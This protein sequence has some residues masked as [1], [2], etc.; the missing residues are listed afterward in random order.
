[1][2]FTPHSNFWISLFGGFL[3]AFA[4]CARVSAAQLMAPSADRAVEI[5]QLQEVKQ[6]ENAWFEV[7]IRA[8]ERQLPITL[9]LRRFAGTGAASFEDGSDE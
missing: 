9:R 5:R 1:M 2:R 3:L 4:S 7:K 8:E 6:G